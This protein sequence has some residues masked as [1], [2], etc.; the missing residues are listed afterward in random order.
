MSVPELHTIHSPLNPPAPS[1]SEH[2]VGLHASAR[3]LALARAAEAGR[4]LIVVTRDVRSRERLEDEIAFY[5]DPNGPPILTFPD[6]EC[7]PYDRFSPHPDILSERLATLAALPHL[8]HGLVLTAAATLMH[9][10]PPASH[11]LGHSFLLQ[12]GDRLDIERFRERLVQAA[13][14]AVGQVM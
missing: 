9:Y 1:G 4:L 14:N 3:G 6:W 12:V 13:Y 2:W 7:L 5:R 10:L 8:T 11:L